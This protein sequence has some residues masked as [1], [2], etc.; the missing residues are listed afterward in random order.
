MDPWVAVSI[1]RE[2]K[3]LR[4]KREERKL[5]SYLVQMKNSKF[6]YLRLQSS[7]LHIFGQFQAAP[8]LE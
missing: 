1:G 7:R 8:T 2:S 4:K 6:Q 5:S 3:H